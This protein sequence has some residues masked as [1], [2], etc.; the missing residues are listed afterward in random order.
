MAPRIPK[1]TALQ[2]F[3]RPANESQVV[4]ASRF[5]RNQAEQ[6]GPILHGRLSSE[7]C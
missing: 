1:R 5:M 6:G 4:H 2:P 7:L 3:I